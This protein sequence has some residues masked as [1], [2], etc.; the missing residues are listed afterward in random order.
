MGQL[1]IR[2]LEKLRK[3]RGKRKSSSYVI[4]RRV[5]VEYVGAD[6]ILR[7]HRLQVH[8]N[9]PRKIFNPTVD[10]IERGRGYIIYRFGSNRKYIHISLY[11]NHDERTVKMAY[12]KYLAITGGGKILEVRFEVQRERK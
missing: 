2:A 9:E 5:W 12:N 4:V 10:I 1:N 3:S 6:G 8:N 11:G 7:R